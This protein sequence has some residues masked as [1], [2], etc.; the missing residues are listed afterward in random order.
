MTA[1]R[2][3]ILLFRTN[4]RSLQQQLRLKFLLDQMKQIERW[5]I[6]TEDRDR[7]LKIISPT[8]KPQ[9]VILSVL[10]LGFECSELE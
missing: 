2:A 5:C 10:S 6:D 4:I 8:L 9:E 3:T 7:V 1:T